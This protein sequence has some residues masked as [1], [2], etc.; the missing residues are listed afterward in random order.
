MGDNN[1]LTLGGAFVAVFLGNCAYDGC[2]NTDAERVGKEAKDEIRNVGSKVNDMSHK[3][4]NI[5]EDVDYVSREVGKTQDYVQRVEIS[6]E[7]V[8]GSINVLK[9]Q[10]ISK[11]YDKK[12]LK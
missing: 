7:E 1:A 11:G 6:L 10:C 3:V 5:S 12:P 2:I 8:K 9:D 4:N